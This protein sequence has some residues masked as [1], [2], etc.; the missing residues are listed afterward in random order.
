MFE[1]CIL[2]CSLDLHQKT[3]VNW[4]VAY[5][6]SHPLKG[7]LHNVGKWYACFPFNEKVLKNRPVVVAL[8]P[9]VQAHSAPYIEY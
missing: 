6:G 8:Y 3:P 2:G 7:V 9:A 5:P 1:S 4:Y